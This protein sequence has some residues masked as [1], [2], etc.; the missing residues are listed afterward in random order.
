MTTPDGL[1]R[2]MAL[3]AGGEP[4][5]EGR[6]G[7]RETRQ[8]DA[9]AQSPRMAVGM[10][11]CGQIESSLAF[12]RIHRSGWFQDLPKEEESPL[13]EGRRPVV[14]WMVSLP[15]KT[16]HLEPLNVV[17]FRV[18]VFVDVMKVRISR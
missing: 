10:H 14:G 11:K 2:R 8:E 12:G 5:G 16:V 9:G 7:S 1:F 4:T 6:C 15:R 17:L 3:A 13:R 18:R